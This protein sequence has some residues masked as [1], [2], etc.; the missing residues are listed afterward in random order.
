M[1]SRG[2]EGRASVD[3]MLRT[4]QQ[5]HIQLSSMAD[6][7]ANIIIALS[8]VVFTVSLSQV[9]GPQIVW[10]FPVLA[11]FAGLS[12]VF[13]IQ[14]VIPRFQSTIHR[15]DEM[16]LLF[17][18]HFTELSFDEYQRR[19]KEIIADDGDI[20]E[21]IMRDLY[22]IGHLLK[23]KKYRNLRVSYLIFWIGLVVALVIAFVQLS[24]GMM[25]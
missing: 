25:G 21:A 23:H 7:K 16:N 4:V 14:A 10:A 5:H 19:M 15:K 3:H 17:F 2:L 22:Q 13:A 9:A 18:G 8:S 12:L 1:A 6:Q 20:Y 11:V 24:V